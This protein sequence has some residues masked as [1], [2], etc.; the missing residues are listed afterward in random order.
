MSRLTDSRECDHAIAASASQLAGTGFRQSSPCASVGSTAGCHSDGRAGGPTRFAFDQRPMAGCQP[1][2]RC[3]AGHFKDVGR[4]ESRETPFSR[5]ELSPTKAGCPHG[6]L[7]SCQCE[8]EP[9]LDQ[10]SLDSFAAPSQTLVQPMQT[11]DVLK[12][13][14]SPAQFA[15]EAQIRAI[16][17]LGLLRASLL[18]QKR[19]QRMP[20]RLHPTPGFVVGQRIVQ[21]NGFAQMRERD[22]VIGN[23]RQ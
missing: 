5:G 4:R 9:L 8:I 15:V 2:R 10:R 1:S 16:D 3:L 12:M 21:F 19:P 20:R 22:A 17:C 13:L 6:N 14:A 7:C 23:C 11:P 18:Q